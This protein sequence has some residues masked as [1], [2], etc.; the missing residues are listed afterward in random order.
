MENNGCLLSWTWRT[1]T[2]LEGAGTGWQPRSESRPHTSR[3]G[4]G[5]VEQSAG[6]QGG[7]GHVGYLPVICTLFCQMLVTSSV[8]NLTYFPFCECRTT[9]EGP[10]PLMLCWGFLR[11]FSQ[12]IRGKQRVSLFQLFSGQEAP[13]IIQARSRLG[14]WA[15]PT[16][17]PLEGTPP[18]RPEPPEIDGGI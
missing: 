16:Q 7:R 2:H 6:V 11:R 8:W 5:E 10:L 13:E 9:D 4:G 18:M 15:A 1:L 14:L 17:G 12:K 3:G